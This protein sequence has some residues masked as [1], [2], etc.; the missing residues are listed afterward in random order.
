MAATILKLG[1]LKSL[2]MSKIED[3]CL[4]PPIS[5]K[6]NRTVLDNLDSRNVIPNREVVVSAKIQ[7]PC[8]TQWSNKSPRTKF[9]LTDGSFSCIFTLFGD[10]RELV[11]QYPVN[12]PIV[13]RG[14]ATFIG[15]AFYLNEAE[16]ISND[17]LGKLVTVY[18][19]K[20]GKCSPQTARKEIQKRLAESIPAACELLISKLKDKLSTDDAIENIIGV[21]PSKLALVLA[22]AHSP[23]SPKHWERAI[24]I[25]E[26]MAIF[27]AAEALLTYKEPQRAVPFFSANYKTLTKDVPFQL[28]SEQKSV[29]GKIVK[30]IQN[31]N[32]LEAVLIG[33]VGTGKTIVF[34]VLA[35]YFAFANKRVAIL[36]PNEALARQIHSE[37]ANSFKFMQ[38]E[39]VLGSC[40]ETETHIGNVVIGTTAILFRE[41]GK[42]DLLICDEQQKLSTSQRAQLKGQ[43]CHYLDVSATPIPRTM[44]IASFGATECFTLTKCHVEKNIITKIVDVAH[45]RAMFHHVMQSV[46]NGKKVLVVCPRRMSDETDKN[47]LPS[48][49]EVA[50][51]FESY[52]PGRVSLAHAGMS[53]AE[54]KAAIA[55]I[56]SGKSSI[57]ISTTYIEVGITIPSLEIMVILG[58]D[59]LGIQQLHQLRGRVAREGGDGFCYLLMDKHIKSEKT[60]ERLSIMEQTCDGFEIARLDMQ[61]RGIGDVSKV[62]SNQHGT[63]DILIKNIKVSLE[64]VEWLIDSVKQYQDNPNTHQKLIA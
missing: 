10:K 39:L 18:K 13:V 28:T 17:E 20:V 22:Q 23:D 33:D 41:V 4:Y 60:R 5:I 11:K 29:I 64:Q 59:K 21:S 46:E 40:K 16:V 3:I 47:G 30:S 51:K 42:F 57:L 55:D 31:G 27:T 63:S 24:E 58:P 49:M 6:D 52:C 38:P 43:G 26:R 2:G 15:N 7:K 54:N 25:L 45:K 14:L 56:K 53:A 8:E 12:K 61:L 44:A 19:G 37:L 1:R 50:H 62:G 48:V 9:T 36:L 32:L 34:G 35:A